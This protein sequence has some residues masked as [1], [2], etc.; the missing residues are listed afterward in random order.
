M[1]H[2]D[3]KILLVGSLRVFV[4]KHDTVEDHWGGLVDN[5]L[6]VDHVDVVYTVVCNVRLNINSNSIGL[7]VGLM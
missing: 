5:L 7:N 6:V 3:S 4:H 1:I 2:N